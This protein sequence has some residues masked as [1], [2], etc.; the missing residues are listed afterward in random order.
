M[1]DQ[2]LSGRRSQSCMIPLYTSDAT[3]LRN[4]GKAQTVAAT[5]AKERQFHQETDMTV[6][7]RSW[8]GDK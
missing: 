5:T 2:Q 6:A 7:R 8:L 1:L 3:E 4:L